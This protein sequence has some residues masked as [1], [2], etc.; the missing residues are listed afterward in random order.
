[1]WGADDLERPMHTPSH[2]TQDQFPA[3]EIAARL[4]A[5]YILI[6]ETSF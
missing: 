2:D 3:Q 6:S 5:G 1:M 4:M